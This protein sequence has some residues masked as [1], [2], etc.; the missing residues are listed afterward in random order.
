MF[1]KLE[2]LNIETIE[3]SYFWSSSK[4]AAKLFFKVTS[5]VVIIQ[6]VRDFYSTYVFENT[7][8]FILTWFSLEN[9]NFFNYQLFLLNF[10]F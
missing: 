2:H 3:T 6:P 4:F 10:F 7:A 1:V 8:S 5:T 9:F